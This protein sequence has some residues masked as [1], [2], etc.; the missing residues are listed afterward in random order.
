MGGEIIE[1]QNNL[2][3][4]MTTPDQKAKRTKQHTTIGYFAAFTILG[5]TTASLG[6]SLPS[7][8][9]NTNTLISQ[10][11]YLFT[12]RSGGYLIGS[13]MGGRTYDRR[14]GHHVLVL[15]LLAIAIALGSIPTLSQLWVLMVVLM[16]V[17]FAEGAVDVGGN[18]L[19]VWL[20]RRDV[21][22]YMNALHAF[23]GVGSF[24]SP[25]ILA[26]AMRSSGEITFGYW[27]LA[28]MVIPV[29]LWILRLPS[30]K[31]DS[32]IDTSEQETQAALTRSN[33]I[34]ILIICLFLFLYVGAEVSYGGWIYTYALESNLASETTAAYLNSGFWGAFTL[35]RLLSIPL[36][37]RIRPRRMLV[38]NLVGC[39]L[40][41]AIML[42]WSQSTLAL[43]V[44]SIGIGASM[45]SIFPTTLTMAERRLKITGQITGWFFVGASLGGMFLPWF[46][47]Q[48]FES[49]GPQS[50]MN[51][52][53]LDLILAAMIFL[54]VPNDGQDRTRGFQAL[55]IKSWSKRGRKR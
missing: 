50:M 45:A 40:S 48:F 46:I 5:L 11:S 17:G 37:T 36:A 7:L 19:L 25:I 24:L 44:G 2:T 21:S 20:Y 15:M 32:A 49:S 9:E 29:I 22:P 10:I 42:L 31:A 34:L 6:P 38:I 43:W 52:I 8:A 47:G 27:A 1:N 28:L 4:M 35:S 13:W 33:I 18:T 39:L 30:P 16:I 55:F 26:L 12:A 53:M 23:F 3:T 51:I 54:L 41:T 14:P